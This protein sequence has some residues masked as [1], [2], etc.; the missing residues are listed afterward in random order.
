MSAV[1]PETKNSWEEMGEGTSHGGNG[2]HGGGKSDLAGWGWFGL[3]LA[4]HLEILT[5]EFCFLF[6]RPV[7]WLLRSC[8]PSGTKPIRPSKPSGN[9]AMD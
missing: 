8:C 7:F 2:G 1:W 9:Q 6:S 5:S 3:G 4:R